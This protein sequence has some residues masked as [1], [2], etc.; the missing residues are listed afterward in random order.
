LKAV[1]D[2][3]QGPYYLKDINPEEKNMEILKMGEKAAKNTELPFVYGKYIESVHE[4][5]STIHR[6]IRLVTFNGH[7]VPSIFF[8]KKQIITEQ[9]YRIAPIQGYR[10]VNVFRSTKVLYYNLLNQDGFVARFSRGEF[11][12]I[13]IKTI[14]VSLEMFFKFPELKK[15]YRETL[16]E[17]TN[18]TF[19]ENYLEI[20]KYSK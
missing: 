4:T 5:E 9:G 11:F 14:R 1:S 18:R 15:L 20:N 13:F 12:K 16:P 17:L 2:F 3:L 8:H 6:L 19:W 10:P 7:L